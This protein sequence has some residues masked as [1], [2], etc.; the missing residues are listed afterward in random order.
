MCG[1][2]V[3]AQ[4]V[5]RRATEHTTMPRPIAPMGC[6]LSLTCFVLAV[7][8]WRLHLRRHSHAQQLRYLL[9]HC[10]RECSPFELSLTL[11][12][13]PRWGARFSL[14][15]HYLPLLVAVRRWRW[16]LHLRWHRDPPVEPDLLKH[17][18]WRAFCKTPPNTPPY[19]P[20]RPDGVLAFTD[21]LCVAPLCAR[22]V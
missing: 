21:M 1:S 19:P 18:V 10:H 16:R 17:G 22:R 3:C 2:L 12:P 20:H 9:Q 6:S 15:C 4:G 7:W 5:R 8:R 14:M 11:P 13:S